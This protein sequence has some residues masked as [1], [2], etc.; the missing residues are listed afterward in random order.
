[1][2][3]NENATVLTSDGE[4][5][6]EVERVV[7]D[8]CGGQ[9]THLIVR[10]GVLFTEDKVVSAAWVDSTTPEEIHLTR[11]ADELEPL[12]FFREVHYLPVDEAAEEDRP[13]GFARPLYWYPPIGTAWWGVGGY[14]G[15]PLA[16][17][18]VGETETNIPDDVVPLREG[19]Q[20]I[21][22][23]GESVGEVEG[24]FT[25]RD[26][27]IV[28][29]ILL[30]QGLIFEDHKL[31]PTTW[32]SRVGENEVHLAVSQDFLE[33]VPEFEPESA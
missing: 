33:A 5:V 17:Q 28:T 1:M 7:I 10:E 21:T 20:V 24:V 25:T 23:D 3:F 29:H 26:K 32:I 22:R 18:Y 30:S 9:V 31:V 19:A 2:Q 12:P 27:A 14:M 13:V 15:Y 8:P 4:K 16:T 11:S 6:G